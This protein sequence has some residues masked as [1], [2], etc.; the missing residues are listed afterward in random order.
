METSDID[1]DAYLQRIGYSGPRTPT[2]ET[3]RNLHAL[4]PDAIVFEAI[5]VLLGRG[6]SLDPAV[7]DAKLIAGGRGGYCFEHNG[8]FR[9]A[10]I[11]LG[12]KVEGL[13]GRVR[14]TAPPDAAPTAQTHM[15][16]RVSIDGEAWLAD[17]GFGGCVLTTPLRL[18]TSDVQETK[19]GPF[20]L[21]AA[22]ENQLLQAKLGEIWT[23]TYEF[24]LQVHPDVDYEVGNWF[25]STHP[26]S[27]FRTNLMVA[28]TTDQARYTLLNNRYT[29]RQ[30]NGDTQR[31]LLTADEIEAVLAE[32]F[33]LPVEPAWR[34][35]I[36]RCT[37]IGTDVA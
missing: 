8:L 12:F 13:V 3:L 35:V 20:R 16:L 17:V 5:D 10:L 9:R 22:G 1:L 23:T 15:L 14:W 29:V 4:H 7:V 30:I 26:D 2:L 27:H 32:T 19:H 34:P 25:T 36:A 21:I 24:S 11:A 18:H 28:R 37:A 6:V 33:C 31:R